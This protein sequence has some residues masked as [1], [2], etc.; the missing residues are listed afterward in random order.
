MA[1]P[2]YTSMNYCTLRHR[3]VVDVFIRYPATS[4]VDVEAIKQKL[5]AEPG[6]PGKQSRIEEVGL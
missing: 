2:V 4:V 3:S 5:V 1:I 6:F